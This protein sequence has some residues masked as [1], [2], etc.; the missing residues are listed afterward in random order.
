MRLNRVLA[1]GGIASRRGAEALI[2][3]GRVRVNGRTVYDPALDCDPRRD[4]VEVDGRPLRWP[5]LRIVVALNKPP[6]YTTT[7]RDPHARRTVRELVSDAPAGL[8][9]VGRLD[10]D[11]RGLLLLTNDGELTARLT[12]PRFHVPKVYRV[13]VAGVPGADILEHLRRGI[14][15]ADGP[16]APAEVR[17][18]GRTATDTELEVI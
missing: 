17:V 10:R 5:R 4:H 14:P 12:H 13:R 15:L 7:W 8:H 2:R 3:A 1:R 6:G 18:V 9:P 16:T 11:S